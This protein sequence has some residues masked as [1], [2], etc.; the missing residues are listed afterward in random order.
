MAW[1][2][3]LYG[4]WRQKRL[5]AWLGIALFIVWLGLTAI[6]T[7]STAVAQSA[8]PSS[9]SESLELDPPP[10]RDSYL[11]RKIAPTMSYAHAGWLVRSERQ[12]EEDPKT[13]LEQLQLQPGMIVCDMGCGNG[14][15]S[16][17]MAKRIV[18]GG[19]VLA[20][21][22]Q[23][24]MLHLLHLRA[25]ESGID[26]IETILGELTNPHL[27]PASVDMV[28]MVDVYHEFSHPE[29]MLAAIRKSLKPGGRIALLEFR[30]ED[31]K[32]PILPLHKMSKRQILREYRANGFR[33]AGQFDDLPWQHLMF[34]ESDPDWK[35]GRSK[36]ENTSK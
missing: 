36:K 6:T 1:H 2:E 24:E 15:Y 23:Q 21:D 16:M 9:E 25:E 5:P 12:Q 34:F 32:V 28:L 33:L 13:A 3:R 7:T 11:G 19:K 18:P 10:A 14:F 26:N 20:V 35:S 29:Q 31:P 30:A 22:I 17:E 4:L 8:A 27:P